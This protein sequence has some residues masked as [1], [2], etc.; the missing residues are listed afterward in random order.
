LRLVA[1]NAKLF[2]P[3]GTIYHI[4]AD[5]ILTWGLD[6][7]AKAAPTVIQYETDWNIEIE[8]DDDGTVNIDDDD[9]Y[10]EAT[11]MDVDEAGQTGRSPSV[12][13]QIPPGPSRRVTRGPYKKAVP[14]NTV[15]EGI[16]AEGR[17]PGSK[18]GLGAFPPGSDWARTMLA[19]KLKGVI[20]A[21]RMST[22]PKLITIF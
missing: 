21:C 2:N 16:D 12:A 7:I 5:R 14:S 13:S 20:S 11:P 15:S 18:D 19:L 6:H 3:P 4:E 10:P 22:Y 8:K 1:S 9:E 17:F